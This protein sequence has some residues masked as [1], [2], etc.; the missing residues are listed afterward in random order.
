MT[1]ELQLTLE[2]CSQPLKAS[3]N[4][5]KKHSIQAANDIGDKYHLLQNKINKIKE[6]F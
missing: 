1:L 4:E 2:T 6:F 5:H 3:N